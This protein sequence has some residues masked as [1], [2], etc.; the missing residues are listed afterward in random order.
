MATLAYAPSSYAMS[1]QSTPTSPQPYFAF[2]Q[3]K[4]DVCLVQ[5]SQ[6]SSSLMFSDVR[7]FRHE[8]ITI[9]RYSYSTTVHP[10]DIQVLELL[11]ERCTLYEE[12]GETVSLSRDVMSRMQRLSAALTAPS[13]PTRMGH[14]YR[15][16]QASA[17]RTSPMARIH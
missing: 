4:G 11:D 13:I 15:R 17:V 8:F 2:A 6:P 5:L 9:F 1:A 12:E 10:T 14:A 7:V 3:I 16:S